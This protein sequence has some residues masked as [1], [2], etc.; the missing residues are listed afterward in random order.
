MDEELTIQRFIDIHKTKYGTALSEVKQGYK[1]SHWM[2]YIFPQI[3]GLPSKSEIAQ[4]YSIQDYDEAFE[5][6]NDPFLGGHLREISAALLE[7][8]TDRAEDIFGGIDALKLRS[9]MT[10]FHYV[11]G[12]TD[13]NEVFYRVLQK[14]YHG[15]PDNLTIDIL[16]DY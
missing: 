5:F 6:L 14:F 9:C 3:K 4:Y 16:E 7:L 15:E 11:G 8:E 1:E 10:L 2:W 12:L 13:E